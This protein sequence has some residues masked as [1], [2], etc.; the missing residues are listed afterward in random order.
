MHQTICRRDTW[1]LDYSKIRNLKAIQ[2]VKQYN[3]SLKQLSLHYNGFDIGHKLL[4]E[5]KQF[6]AVAAQCEVPFGVQTDFVTWTNT[7]NKSSKEFK[8]PKFP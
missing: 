3:A 7:A 1:G 5:P 2:K 8:F 6:G 4:S